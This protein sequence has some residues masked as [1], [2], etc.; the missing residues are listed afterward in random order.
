[1][2]R[3]FEVSCA[4]AAFYAEW[5]WLPSASP[6]T[7]VV[8]PRLRTLTLQYTQFKW[9]SPMLR[10]NLR[11]LNLRSLPTSHFPLD[12]I[13]YIISSNP[14]LEVL[15]L[16]FASVLPEILPLCPTHLPEMKE[17]N[18]GGHYLLSRIVDALTLPVVETLN[19]DVEARDPIE[20][21]ISSLLVRSNKPPLTHLGVAYGSS[22][23][24]AFYYGP[25]GIV[26]SWAVL[27]E[28]TML[29][30]LQIG[31]TPLEPLLV[32]LGPPDED[33]V[34]HWA[35][36]N[37]VSLGMKNCHSHS[38]AV[39]KL[40]QMVDA[41][42]PDSSAAGVGGAT[43]LNGI[44]P[45]KLRQLEMYDCASLGQDVVQWLKGRIDEV[46]CTEPTYER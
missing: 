6:N 43:V 31:G 22:N 13:L 26:I 15:S 1:M 25:A 19:L 5:P 10:T 14:N 24:S 16:H 44:T 21:I 3:E 18:I 29:E 33:G 35:C 42:N 28:L 32:A 36:P 38:E 45:V 37:L 11:T 8:L 46:V 9:S 30:S 23:A 4:E 41:R 20:D 39:A 12:R 7:E 17:L 34:N 40:V 27:A 2:L